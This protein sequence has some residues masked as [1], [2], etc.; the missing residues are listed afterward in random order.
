MVLPNFADQALRDVPIRVFGTG[1]QSRCFG[2][3]RESVEALLRLIETPAAIGE[4]VNL[5]ADREVTIGRLAEMVRDIVDSSSDIAHVPYDEAYAQGF[6]DLERRA[7]DVRK[8]E[9][10]TG[11]RFSIPLEQIIE[12][13]VEDQRRRIVAKSGRPSPRDRTARSTAS[14]PRARASRRAA[15]ARD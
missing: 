6:E 15:S 8:L 10:L 14:A 5:G 11:F 9:Q 4:V 2:N 3:V 1:Y 7:P 12:D 13:V